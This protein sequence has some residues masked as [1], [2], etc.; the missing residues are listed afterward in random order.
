M[1]TIKLWESG[2]ERFTSRVDKYEDNEEY[3]PKL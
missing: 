1:I 3:M 2:S